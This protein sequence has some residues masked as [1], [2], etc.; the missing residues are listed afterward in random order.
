MGF[1]GEG[2]CFEPVCFPFGVITPGGLMSDGEDLPGILSAGFWVGLV[3]VGL[4]IGFGF[5]MMNAGL[6]K[7]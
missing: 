3:G 1:G 5:L 2:V 7:P 4:V 6:L